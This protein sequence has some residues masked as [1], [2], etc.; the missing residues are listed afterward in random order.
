[1]SYH[2]IRSSLVNID[3]RWSMTDVLNLFNILEIQI[4][5]LCFEILLLFIVYGLNN[6]L[7]CTHFVNNVLYHV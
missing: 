5:K 1:M 7:N 6:F 2:L 3:Q 4:L